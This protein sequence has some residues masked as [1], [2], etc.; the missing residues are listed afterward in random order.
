MLV[1]VIFGFLLANKARPKNG[2]GRI[3]AR[4][5]GLYLMGRLLFQWLQLLLPYGA[6][7]STAM[8]L[9]MFGIPCPLPALSPNIIPKNVLSRFARCYI[10]SEVALWTQ[11]HFSAG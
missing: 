10:E 4:W 6:C 2:G 11:T 1:R 3:F 7:S 5:P 9:S 8:S